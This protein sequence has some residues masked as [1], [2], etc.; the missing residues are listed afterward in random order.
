MSIFYYEK[1]NNRSK[2]DLIDL[3][4]NLNLTLKI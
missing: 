3:L 2:L 4:I 1:Q